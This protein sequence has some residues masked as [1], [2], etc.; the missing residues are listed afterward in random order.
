M[1]SDYLQDVEDESGNT[2]MLDMNAHCHAWLTIMPLDE[3]KD[4]VSLHL[5]PDELGWRNAMQISEALKNWVEH[6]KSI[7]K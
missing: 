4:S 3:E 1:S 7:K 5:S 6:S 2:V